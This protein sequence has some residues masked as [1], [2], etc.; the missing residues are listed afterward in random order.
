MKVIVLAGGFDQ[1]ALINELKSRGA[2]VILV[3]YFENP[4][5]K[6]V[7]DKHYKEST[8][9]IEAVTRIA[10]SEKVD[11]IT[12]ACTDQALLT[13]AEVSE[14]LSLPCY[15]TL[16]TAKNVTNKSLM[17]T[18][19]EKN[20]IPTAKYRIVNNA[21]LSKLEEL[22]FP[23]VV[24]PVDCNSSK[25]VKKVN[26]PIELSKAI[27]DAVQLSRTK[28]AVVEEFK[29]GKEIS[30][31]AYVS[32]GV[33]HVMLLTE[34]VKIKNTNGFTI[35][36][37]IYPVNITKE[38]ERKIKIIA[39]NIANVF[40]INDS[41]LLIQ[42]I[43]TGEDVFVLEFSARMG[44]GT[45]YKLIEVLTGV[46]IM[47]VY[48]SRVLGDKPKVNCTYNV[49]Y[50]HLNYCYCYPCI[51][52]KLYNFD[53]LKERGVIEDYF[54]YKS[55]GMEILKAETS[56]DRAAGYLIVGSTID[57]LME[58]ERI[59][60]RELKILSIDGKDVFMRELFDNR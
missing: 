8:L 22:T 12:T 13:V 30:V 56:S 47:S 23:L 20:Q 45:K 44:G 17:K 21:D 4:P 15:L 31:D 2:Y 9:D 1:I 16:E 52:D 34:S 51:F 26:Y 7:A 40:K 25:G 43:V 53:K 49:G 50:C 35:T 5:A 36:Q 41:P 14:K 37:S 54:Q 24:K 29:S 55:S 59:A 3:D 33:A 58:K 10:E 32:N 38:A 11:L 18:I 48:V 39:Q 60:N 6:A 28:T 57:E 42:F 46:D 27:E 19:M